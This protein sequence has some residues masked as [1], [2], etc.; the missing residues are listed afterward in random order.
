MSSKDVTALETAL[1][2]ALAE[3][4]TSELDRGVCLVGPHRDELELSV[5]GMPARGYASH[6]ESWSLA[7]ALRLASFALLREGREDPVLIL[8]DVF[9][10]LDTGRRDRLAALVAGAEQVLITAAVPADVPAVLDGARY[11]VSAGTVTS[12]VG[13]RSRAAGPSGR[14]GTDPDRVRLAV[15]ALAVAKA[16]ARGRGDLPAGFGRGPGQTKAMI[17]NGRAYPR[18]HPLDARR[19]AGRGRP[20]REDPQLLASAIGGLLD[21]HGWQQRA[22]MGSV[23]GRWAEIVGADLAAH[24]RAGQFRRRRAG[25]HGGLDR[26]GDPGPAARPGARQ[27]AQRRARRRNGAPGQGPRPGRAAPARRLAR[28]RQQG[29]RRHVRITAGRL[30]HQGK[31]DRGCRCPKVK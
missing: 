24:T 2:K 5:G 12:R 31:D 8:D 20:R 6:G 28:S 3:V 1:L 16:D 26:L 14:A 22:A 30:R 25:G 23:F 19:A 7:L 4:R 21:T 11:T 27:A 15:E 17:P 10:E 29:A 18:P 13:A 9:A